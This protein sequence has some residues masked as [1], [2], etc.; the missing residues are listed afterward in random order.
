MRLHIL[1]FSGFVLAMTG[2][3]EKEQPAPEQ[4]SEAEPA[5]MADMEEPVAASEMPADQPD[6][7][8]A[9]IEEWRDTEL[10]EHMHAHAEQ[11]DDLNIA[12]DDGDLDAA[13]T[14]AYWLSNHKMVRGLPEELEPFVANMRDAAKAVEQAEDLDTARA[15][16]KKI[17][18]E[19]QGCHVA[20][21]FIDET[22]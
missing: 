7:T 2:C 18:A 16:A 12:L 6:E 8:L 13:A 3:A 5:V 19:C 10:L 14:P 9:K 17:I 15:A 11:L 4:M 20:T 21:G 22:T 1:I